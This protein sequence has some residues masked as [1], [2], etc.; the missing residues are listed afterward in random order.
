MLTHLRLIARHEAHHDL[1]HLIRAALIGSE[2]EAVNRALNH[3]HRD[4]RGAR[5]L[6]RWVACLKRDLVFVEQLFKHLLTRA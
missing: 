6:C 3:R 1:N 5:A 2:R 4:G